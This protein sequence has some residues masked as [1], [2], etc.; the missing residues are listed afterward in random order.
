MSDERLFDDTEIEAFIHEVFEENF[1]QLRLESGHSITHSTK[2]AA[3]QQVLLYWRRLHDI[4]VRITDTETVLSLPGQETPHER[5]YTIEGVVDIV[6][7]EDSVTMYDIKTHD[8]DYIRANIDL[9]EQQL[10]VYAYI[11]EELRKQPLDEA[12]I[13]STAFPDSVRRALESGDPKRLEVA[14]AKW[15][16][17]IPTAHDPAKRDRTLYEFGRIVD[18]IEEGEF[19]APPIERLQEKIP[20]PREE[21]F[22][23]RVC[24]NCDARFSCDSYRSYAAPRGIAGMN[25][26][27]ENDPDV[28]EWRAASLD[29]FPDPTILE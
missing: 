28:E 12:A 22:A 10:N 18:M 11:W 2:E 6:R 1:E 19:E 25:Y 16:P 13:I 5:E 23:V 9:Y 20:G 24:R 4:A 15:D 3:L 17:I 8:A 21:R 14:L 26:F 27:T 29:G 7:E